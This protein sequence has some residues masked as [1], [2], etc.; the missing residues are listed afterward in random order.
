[1]SLSEIIQI[2]IGDRAWPRWLGWKTGRW[3]H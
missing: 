2:V 3:W 1:M